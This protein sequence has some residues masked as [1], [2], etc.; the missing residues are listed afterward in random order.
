[1]KNPFTI[2]LII[3]TPIIYLLFVL[4]LEP[5]FSFNF[6]S[7]P[8]R[9]TIFFTRLSKSD[10]S[11]CKM[12]AGRQINQFS[13]K[14]TFNDCK[15]ERK[16]YLK[17]E[18]QSNFLCKKREDRFHR[19]IADKNY[20]EKRAGS[21]W[22]PKNNESIIQNIEKNYGKY[23]KWGKRWFKYPIK[24]LGKLSKDQKALYKIGNKLTAFRK[25]SFYDIGL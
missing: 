16:S 8:Y 3:F 7:P 23:D 25:C 5:K 13:A 18:K 9:F 24:D 10:I 20:L 6:L 15:K 14:Q 1:M 2:P 17:E 19:L 12:M 21:V 22:F 4:S 11:Y